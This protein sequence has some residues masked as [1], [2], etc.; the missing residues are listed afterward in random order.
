MGERRWGLSFEFPMRDSCGVLVMNDRRR[1]PERR[2]DNTTMEERLLM[3]SGA[4]S[5]STDR[6]PH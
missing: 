1:R 3:F 4:V 5:P 2:L 6:D